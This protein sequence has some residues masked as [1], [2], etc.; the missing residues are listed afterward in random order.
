MRATRVFL[1]AVVCLA[2]NGFAAAESAPLTDVVVSEETATPSGAWQYKLSRS[3]N[4][5]PCNGGS[6]VEQVV[7][8]LNHSHQTLECRLRVD[9]KGVDGMIV[10]SFDGPAVVLPNTTPV[11]HSLTTDSTLTAEIASVFCTARAPYQRIAKPA[12]CKYDMFGEPFERYYPPDAMERSLQGPVIVSFE[13][14]SANGAAKDLVIAQSSLV[15]VLDD[16]ARRFI[17]DQM[18]STNCPGQRF[19]ILMRFK[20][21]DQVGAKN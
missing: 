1:F 10:R 2:R 9:Y 8:V 6:C 19:D 18:F 14:R 13:L 7:T 21:R 11:V 5:W 3:A 20:L 17:S 15:P 12:N 4:A 16:A